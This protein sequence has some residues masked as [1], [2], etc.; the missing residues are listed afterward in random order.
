[1]DSGSPFTILNALPDTHLPHEDFAA[2]V[3]LEARL[4]RSMQ[5]TQ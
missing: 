3:A 5:M 2:P 1:M 4:H